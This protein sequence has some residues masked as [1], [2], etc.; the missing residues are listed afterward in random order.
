MTSR[1]STEAIAR[2]ADA[3]IQ[4]VNVSRTV[5]RDLLGRPALPGDGGERLVVADADRPGRVLL[6]SQ[7]RAAGLVVLSVWQGP[8][9]MATVRVAER[10][11]PVLRRA[12][13]EE[14]AAGPGEPA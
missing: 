13:G 2:A 4:A 7:R 9:C 1:S 14:P 6:V 8:T 5:L 3:W 10:D 11:L 12:L